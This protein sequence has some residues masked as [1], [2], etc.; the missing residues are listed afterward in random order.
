MLRLGLAAIGLLAMTVAALSQTTPAPMATTS[1]QPVA[2]AP[3]PPTILPA[4]NARRAG[5]RGFNAGVPIIAGNTRIR[6]DR[7]GQVLTDELP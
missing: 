2:T 7:V 4:R 1:A 3:P 5:S 6:I